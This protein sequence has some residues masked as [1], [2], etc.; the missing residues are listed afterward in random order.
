KGAFDDVDICMMAHNFP[1]AAEGHNIYG[2]N[3]GNGFIHKEMRFVGKQAHAGAA[4]WEGVNALNMATLAINT[5]QIQRETFKDSDHVRV[6]Q[7]ITKGGQ[8]VN[9]VPAE[10]CVEGSVRAASLAAVKDANAKVN[11]SVHG[12][13]LGGNAE[14]RDN[15]G[16][17]PMRPDETLARLFE[18]NAGRFY[19]SERIAHCMESTASFDIGDLSHMMPILHGITS[20]IEGGLHAKDYR[21]VNEEDAYITPVKILACTVIDLLYNHA[22]QAKAIK[23]AFCPALT[24]EQYLW[25][26]REMEKTHRYE[27][28]EEMR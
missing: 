1:I 27:Y 5:I 8:M 15:P 23:E 20:G 24:K 10:V 14:V 16:Y 28:L 17:L 9:A 6:H 12:V 25:T 7:I 19:S 4:P 13:A 18:E 11:R 22:E 2:M 26:L 3:T 21:I